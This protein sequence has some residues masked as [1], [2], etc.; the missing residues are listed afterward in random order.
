[1]GD[2][3]LIHNIYSLKLRNWEII[4]LKFED[5]NN[6]DINYKSVYTSKRKSL[7]TS[8]FKALYNELKDLI[9]I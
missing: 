4:L 3:L 6:K 1:M 2:A 5:V 9:I 8:C 7:T